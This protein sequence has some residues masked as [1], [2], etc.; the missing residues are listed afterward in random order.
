MEEIT[1]PERDKSLVEFT[2]A[3]I[4]QG[5]ASLGAIAVAIVGLCGIEPLLMLSIATLV[6]GVALLVSGRTV[7]VR[8]SELFPGVETTYSEEIIGGGMALDS[9]AGLAGIVL[10]VLALVGI[11]SRILLPAAAITFGGAMLLAGGSVARISQLPM[12]EFSRQQWSARQSMYVASGVDLLCGAGAI[13]L[14]ILSLSG[15]DNV[16]LTLIAFLAIG[17]ANLLMSF[18]FAR[19]ASTVLRSLTD[20]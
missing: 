12:G 17:C 6:I 19:K 1:S 3:S 5:I 14:G 11:D 16:G 4:L 9:F 13:V 15:Y 18:A 10:G 7:A 20:I 8:E 2:G